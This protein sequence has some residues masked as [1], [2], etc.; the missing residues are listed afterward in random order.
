[1]QMRTTISPHEDRH[2]SSAKAMAMAI[3]ISISTTRRTMP[4]PASGVFKAAV[5]CVI[6]HAW[7]LP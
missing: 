1:M 6:E 2:T 3:Q 7:H 5:N 4:M